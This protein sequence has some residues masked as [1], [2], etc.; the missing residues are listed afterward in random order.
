MPVPL[1]AE[2]LLGRLQSLD[3]PRH[4]NRQYPLAGI[5]GALILGLLN[6]Q[7]SGSG[8]WDW[9]RQHWHHIWRPLGFH[10]PHCPVYSTVW[11]L[12]HALDAETLDQVIASWLEAVLGHPVGGLSVDGKTLRG[13]RRGPLAG[14]KLVSLFQHE[15]G[16][17]LGQQQV[18]SGAGEQSI[19]LALLQATPLQGRVV[20]LDAGLI[21]AEATQVIT[22]A[23]GDYVGV[24]KENYPSVKADIDAWIAW[25]GVAFSP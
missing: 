1:P 4:D 6:G 8:A 21:S 16:V 25:Q 22:T 12:L 24:V 5:L 15:L 19:A 18:P 17:V 3:D 23:G 11:N 14:L 7:T 13:S 10:S 20:T 2:S 9:A